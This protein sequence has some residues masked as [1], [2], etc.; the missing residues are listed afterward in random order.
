MPSAGLTSVMAARLF[1]L[2]PE[3]PIITIARAVDLLGTTK[4]TATKA[5]DLLVST[6]VLAETANR[7]RDR[8]FG[9]TAYLTRLRAGTE[10]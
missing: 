4:P 6:G 7:R 9:Y 2:L 1:E 10:I 8:Q 3:H 5:V